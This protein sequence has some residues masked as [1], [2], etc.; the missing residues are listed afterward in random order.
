MGYIPTEWQTGDIITAEK[1]NKAEEGIA[2]AGSFV[3]TITGYDEETYDAILSATW[4][5]VFDALSAGKMVLLV[6]VEDDEV[7]S[8]S[9]FY[10]CGNMQPSEPYYA[11]ASSVGEDVVQKYVAIGGV[12]SGILK[13]TPYPGD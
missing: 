2:A 11:F 9:I 5:E 10:T 1:L 6:Q 4:Q 12:A 7:Y 8:Q 3:V 13:Q